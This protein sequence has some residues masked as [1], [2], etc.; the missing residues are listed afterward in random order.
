MSNNMTDRLKYQEDE[1]AESAEKLNP[2]VERTFEDA[3]EQ[4]GHGRLNHLVLFTSGLIM[5]NVSMESVGMSYAI[6]A[7]E[8]E[9]QLTSKDKGLVNAAAFIGII[10]T[11]FLWG[12]LG[13]R[14]GRRAVM[15]PA[16]L[17][18]A[19]F[20]II[21][22]FATN[23]WMLLVFRFLT[24]CLISASSAT[25]Y[26]YLGEMHANSKRAA[27]IAWSS[28]FISFS[29]II[30]PGLAWIIIPGKWSFSF[31]YMEI[32]P[33]RAF[34]WSWCA[35]G[36]AAAVIL[37]FLPESPRYLLAAKGPDAA[38]P[39]LA[40]MYA[41][42]NKGQTME[43]FPVKQLITGSEEVKVGG[44]AGAVKNVGLMFKVPL[45]R[46]VFISHISMFAV[47]MVSSGLYVW[48]PDILNSILRSN[49]NKS[50]TICQIIHDKFV[51]ASLHSESAAC[52]SEVSVAV[53]PISMSM[54]AVF[55]LTYLAIGFLI[56]KVGKKT[57]Y[58]GIMFICGIATIGAAFVPEGIAATVLLIISLC[59]GCAASILAAIAVD[60]FPTQLR[61]MAMC[62]MYM[63]GRTGAAVGSN[64]LGATLDLHCHEA[65][66]AFGVF[67]AGSTIL[68]IF[69]PDPRQVRQQL[70]EKGFTY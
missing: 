33:W 46:C 32:V 43:D 26:A 55:A 6:T 20:S 9:L 5:L 66:A 39:V 41:W 44:F 7:A 56:N 67:T 34:V 63:V 15:L 28:A 54:G 31:A 70:E 40:M 38:L 62:V 59:S 4:T 68:M 69:W 16:I 30:L 8:C 51:N 52:E 58:S 50:I 35:P 53:F 24:G 65:F 64:F 48:V 14:I 29:F 11:S 60:V 3:F 57:L 19:V 36:L 22:S 1:D 45:L 2:T 42:N 49:T 12:Y 13:D 37:L 27:A 23:V 47:F 61:A 25:V 21:S 17:L 10:S 18:S